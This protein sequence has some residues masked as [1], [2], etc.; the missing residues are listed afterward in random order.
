MWEGAWEAIQG[1][2][3]PPAQ[4]ACTSAASLTSAM[5]PLHILDPASHRLLA[6]KSTTHSHSLM[7][8]C[9]SN[10]TI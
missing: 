6:K 2:A 3:T 10:H 4:G 9:C 8:W 5:L 7:W 1:V